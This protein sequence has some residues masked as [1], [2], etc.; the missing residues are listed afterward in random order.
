MRGQ[1]LPEFDTVPVLVNE[2]KKA[3]HTPY[4]VGWLDR[5]SLE[6]RLFL[7]N[8]NRF[9]II[10][11]IVYKQTPI[12]G[13]MD[14]RFGPRTL[15]VL[16]QPNL[17]HPNTSNTKIACHR[18]NESGL[19]EYYTQLLHKLFTIKYYIYIYLRKMSIK[20]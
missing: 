9:I 3:L 14:K 8:N 7:L 6:T 2:Q 1:D 11:F 19:W 10:D 15:H 20:I 4:P 17:I 12:S 5:C 13:A 18:N 16:T